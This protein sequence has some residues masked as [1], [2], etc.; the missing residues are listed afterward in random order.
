MK[1]LKDKFNLL[2]QKDKLLEEQL[3]LVNKRKTQD[4][5]NVQYPFDTKKNKQADDSYVQSF[6]YVTEPNVSL[7]PTAMVRIEINGYVSIPVRAMLDTG[8]HLNLLSSSLHKRWNFP[9]VPASGKLVGVNGIPFVIKN[10]TLLKIK[11]WFESDQYIQDVFWILPKDS[12]WQPV[13]PPKTVDISTDT[14]T[15]AQPYA[16]PSFWKPESVYILLGTS[17]F[18]KAV[19]SVVARN[20]DGTVLLDTLLGIVVFGPHYVENDEEYVQTITEIDYSEDNQLDKL[21]ARLWEMDQIN[22]RPKRTEE[23]ERVEQHFMDTHRRDSNGVFIVKIP[24]K[25]NIKDIGSSREIALRRFMCLERKLEKNDALR[26]DYV[27][28][29]RQSISLGH[30]QVAVRRPN[31]GELVYYIPHHCIEKKKSRI[32][33]DASCKTDKGISLNQVQMLGERLQRDLHEVVMRLRRHRIALCADIT[34]MYNQVKLS[35]EQ[36]NLQRIFWRENRHEPLREYWLTVVFFGS[37]SSAHL[38]VRS[39]VQAAREAKERFP[40]A[41]NVIENDFYMDDCTT[42]Q[43]DEEKAIKLAKEMKTI[44]AGAGFNLCQWKSNSVQVMKEMQSELDQSS[45]LFSDEEVS[46]ILGLK[47]LISKDQFTFVVKTISESTGVLTKR[48]IT[49]LVARIYDPIG[50]ITP[51]IIIGRII[52]QDLWRLGIQWDKEVPPEIESR[53]KKYWCEIKQLENFRIDRWLRTE[54]DTV[55]EIHGFCDASSMAYGAVLYVRS[56]QADGIG[57]ARLLISKGRVAPLKTVTIP[58]LELS[59]AELLGRLLTYV[60]TS[61]EWPNASYFLWTDSSA[62]LGWIEKTP[63]DLKVFVG[64][65][66][67]SIQRNTETNRWHYINTKENPADLLSRGLLPSEIVGNKLW[68]HGPEWLKLPQS[69]WPKRNPLNSHSPEVQNEM[70]IFLV[71]EFRQ[72]LTIN[73][74]NLDERV[75]LFEYTSRLEKLVNIVSFMIR[76]IDRWMENPTFKI[77]RRRNFKVLE[78]PTEEEKSRALTYLLRKAQEEYYNAEITALKGKHSFPEKSKVLSLKPM[79]DSKGLLRARGR[80]DRSDEPYEMKHPVIVPNGSRLAWLIIDNVHRNTKHGAVQLMMQVIRQR[81]WIP[82]LRS[83]LRSFI[84]KCVICARYSQKLESQLMADLPGDRVQTGKPFLHSGVDY[85]GP[86]ELKMID[87]EGSQLTKRKCWVSIFVCLKTRAMHIDIVTDLTSTAFI[88][89]YERFIARRGRCERMYS[90]N[91]TSFVGAY[92]ELKRAL[93]KWIDRKSLDHF[94]KRSTEWKFMVPAAPHQGGIYEAA[95]KS[96]KFHL[97]R[98]VGTKVLP[99]EQFQTLIVQIEA[100]L[101]SRPIHPLSDD[102]NDVQALTPGHFLIGEPFV[103]PLPFEINKQSNSTGTKLWRERQEMLKHFW[104]RWSSEYLTTLQERK[105]WRREKENL[106]IGQLVLI[107]GENFPPSHWAL[108]RICELICSKDGLVRSVVVQTETS[109]LSRPVQKICIVPVEE[110]KLNN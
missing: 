14:R 5:E 36:W 49:S 13:L 75:S 25:E 18:A 12:E 41:A 96:M 52:G 7:I 24:L 2:D 101:N 73:V 82:K 107:K 106:K 91:G 103:L 74:K 19:N 58:R 44:L 92:N 95:V 70:K 26:K 99:F 3:S 98:I 16:D 71:T 67:A 30:L 23:E 79:L 54:S 22:T 20:R 17:F 28:K 8:A 9:T 43:D 51:V 68:L 35:R 86:F 55:V 29:M 31:P 97:K 84:H 94:S 46:S 15:V 38:A 108:G 50:C 78:P 42:G 40:E 61:M 104:Q 6:N 90:D 69:E 72:Q 1:I 109:K 37:T 47:W 77:R 63:R 81:F 64:N 85:A 65:R 80:L 10:K 39:M 57:E 48:K 76:F 34:K 66:V 105:K 33:F 93:E 27:E 100:V 11:P 89:C 83:E 110:E 21:L 56:V 4:K 53:W 45:I 62:V 88:A 59:A 87:K 32:V 102:P 60:K